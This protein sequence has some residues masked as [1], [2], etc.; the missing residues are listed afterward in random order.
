M[1]LLLFTVVVFINLSSRC[2]PSAEKIFALL[3]GKKFSSFNNYVKDSGNKDILKLR[4]D[5]F[6]SR[7]IIP[8]FE[9]TVV[10][11]FENQPEFISYRINLLSGDDVIFFYEIRNKSGD[12]TIKLYK[13]VPVF[14][15]FESKFEEIYGAR[16]DY[17]DLFLTDIV[18]GDHCGMIGK[19]PGECE[20]MISYVDHWDILSLRKWLRSPNVEKQ[21]YG[22]RGIR[23]LEKKGYMLTT[24]ELRI[25]KIL[26]EKKGNV[27]TC[28]GCTFMGLPI[29]FVASE[30]A[31]SYPGYEWGIEDFSPKPLHL[32][33]I[34]GIIFCIILIFSVGYGL[35]NKRKDN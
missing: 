7:E 26:Q 3:D 11:V 31:D 29:D 18:F 14:E 20:Q 8:R 6:S 23:L 34:A 12:S 19:N 21:M 16:M 2:Q 4:I 24:G 10:D 28:S 32:P 9:E 25:F 17:A 15:Q 1:R 22:A 27:H 30:I 13:N 5:P 35:K 33:T